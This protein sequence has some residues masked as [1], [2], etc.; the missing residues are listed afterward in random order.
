MNSPSWVK[1]GFKEGPPQLTYENNHLHRQHNIRKK[2][3]SLPVLP[4]SAAVIGGQCDR[5]EG[6]KTLCCHLVFLA[7]N[8]APILLQ[9]LPRVQ[10]IRTLTTI[11]LAFF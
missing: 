3:W 1:T 10:S 2:P 9:P 4:V 7:Q 8:I 11:A 6:S 5:R